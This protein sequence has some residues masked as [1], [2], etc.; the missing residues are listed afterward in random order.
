[1]PQRDIY[2]NVILKKIKDKELQVDKDKG[3]VYG[4]RKDYLGNRKSIGYKNKY[5]DCM[6]TFIYNRKSREYPISRA[7]Y[8]YHYGYVKK[9]YIT[10]NKDGD[11]NNN[12]LNNLELKLPDKKYSSKVKFWSKTDE[13]FVTKNFKKMSYKKIGEILGRSEKAI[14]HKVKNLSFEKKIN[15]RKWTEKDDKLLV[16]LYKE[17]SK[18]VNEISLLMNKTASSI[19]LRA[20]RL[21]G[22]YRSNQHLKD[23][24]SID[25]F[26]NAMKHAN[27][28][29]SLQMKCCL[30]DYNK[31]IHLH[32]KD[33]N[34]K[35][36]HIS[37]ISTLCPNHHAETGGGDHSNEKLYAI[38]WRVYKD[39]STGEIKNNL[40]YI[41]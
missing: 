33:F 10:Y 13:Q 28:R 41:E 11:K 4:H 1:M 29:G 6:F 31:Y 14:K 16:K 7:V 9:G 36:N 17:S 15:R 35:N 38:W 23:I 37:N 12:S 27:Q 40:D 8:I 32:H 20:N 30:C 22:A 24:L 25:S 26:Y 34:R 21:F 2:D 39:N 18:S 5:G 19:R 3:L